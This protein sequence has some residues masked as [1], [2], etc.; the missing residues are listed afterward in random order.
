MRD[1]IESRSVRVLM[2]E[3]DPGDADL[4]R[5]YIQGLEDEKL[6]LIQAWSLS[7]AIRLLRTERADLVLLDLRLPDG[8]GV[9]SVRRIRSAARETPIIVLT[10]MTDT[11]LGLSCV[12]HGAQDFLSKDE[13]DE[14]VLRRAIGYSISRVREA[15]TRELE[16][17]LARYRA[18]SSSR[19]VSAVSA[20]LAWPASLEELATAYGGLLERFYHAGDEFPDPE[21]A[22]DLEGLVRRLGDLGGGPR[23]LL[24]IHVR[25]LERAISPSSPGG[26]GRSLVAEGRLMALEMMSLLVDY[27]RAGPRPPAIEDA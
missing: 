13:L 17:T 10:N 22:A 18:M 21:L 6:E 12:D 15:R 1:T 5:E 20:S 2:V 7:Q 14:T 11:E 8:A 27:Y 23:E 24:D 4:I 16:E 26:Q 9:E 19:S 25:A 3:D